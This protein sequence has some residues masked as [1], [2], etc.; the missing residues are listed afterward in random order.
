MSIAE[1]RFQIK[2]NSYHLLLAAYAVMS[3]PYHIVLQ[4]D[5]ETA[6][7]WSSCEVIHR[8]SRFFNQPVIISRFLK[9]ECTTP[10]E[11]KESKTRT[12]II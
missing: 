7:T 4:V 11:L 12:A 2:S 10:A 1:D 3:N 8:W 6:T 5:Q 9:G